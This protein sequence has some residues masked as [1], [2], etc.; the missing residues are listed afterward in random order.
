MNEGTFNG[1][2]GDGLWIL[3]LFI[4]L[5][6]GNG[7]GG[8]GGGDNLYPWMNNAENITAGFGNLQTAISNGFAS[9]E[10]AANSRQMADM[11]QNFA[12]QTQ[13]GDLRYSLATERLWNNA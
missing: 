2:G 6:G 9:A 7:F 13:I 1:F 10:V 5:A 4:L 11:N 3:I 8:F 12:L